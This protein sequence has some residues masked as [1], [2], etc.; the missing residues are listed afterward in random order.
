MNSRLAP[1][2]TQ[3]LGAG[4]P[5]ER[6]SEMRPVSRLDILVRKS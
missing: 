2:A 6:W 1:T 3:Q 4:P 5:Q